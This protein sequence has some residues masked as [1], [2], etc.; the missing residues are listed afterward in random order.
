M[1][2][3]LWKFFGTTNVILNIF[4][5]EYEVFFIDEVFVLLFW[6][7]LKS[8]QTVK[9]A[10]EKLNEVTRKMFTSPTTSS[11][12]LHQLSEQFYYAYRE[13][14]LSI[15]E[16]ASKKANIE[17]LGHIIEELKAITETSSHLLLVVNA[18]SVNPSGKE[19][20]SSAAK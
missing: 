10:A 4:L 14:V 2:K 13:F 17:S 6:K 18:A 7:D 8:R 3:I 19:K 5:F 20:I 15:E 16:G 11:L 9:V 1:K 12:T